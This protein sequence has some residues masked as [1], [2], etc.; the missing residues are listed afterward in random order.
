M[1]V[2]YAERKNPPR[3]LQGYSAFASSHQELDSSIRVLLIDDDEDMP[4]MVNDL[5]GQAQ[6]ISFHLDWLPSAESAIDVMSGNAHQ[7]Y[8]LDYQLGATDGVTLIRAAIDQGCRNPIIMLAGSGDERIVVEAMQSGAVDYIPKHVMSTKSLTRSIRN[9]LEKSSLQNDL[10]RSYNEL[11]ARTQDLQQAHNERQ[12]FYHT[13]AHELKTPLTAGREFV[14]IMLDGLAGSVTE[15]QTEY[16]GHTAECLDRMTRYIND[17]TDVARIETGKL[18]VFPHPTDFS[19]LLELVCAQL[20]PVALRKGI[21]LLS[22]LSP[23]FP[24]L[25]VDKERINQVLV[26][27]VG[28][29]LKFTQAGGT[30]HLQAIPDEPS[31]GRVT[32]QVSDTGS[33]I[34]SDK[35]D[36]IFDRL[37]QVED[38]HT[39]T[40]G[41]LGLGL[42]IAQ[43]LI[44]LHGGS[45]SVSSALG[46]GSTF[47]FSLPIYR[48]ATV[49]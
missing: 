42:T 4:V 10:L 16:L 46:Q 40:Q 34:S 17:L 13:L 20:Q 8:L 23:G 37:Y 35:I 33:G 6:G 26:N 24:K 47:T 18:G 44:R 25:Y 7:A 31:S 27:I 45:L 30:V 2:H 41:G 12:C 36:R 1:S 14:N 49:S 3:T 38:E 29:A 22:T 19:G 28:N 11:E 5:L 21:Q 39:R 32:I 9:A 15:E 48:T 43:E